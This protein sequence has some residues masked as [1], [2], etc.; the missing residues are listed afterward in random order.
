[1]LL[2]GSFSQLLTLFPIETCKVIYFRTTALPF[3]LSLE[4]INMLQGCSTGLNQCLK[5]VSLQSEMEAN[6]LWSALI[7]TRATSGYSI[8][9][10]PCQKQCIL[11]NAILDMLFVALCHFLHGLRERETCCQYPALLR[12]YRCYIEGFSKAE[13]SVYIS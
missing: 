2:G 8:G 10:G 6:S 9:P 4:H 12:L 5:L 1:M 11:Q 7:L 3:Q 13:K